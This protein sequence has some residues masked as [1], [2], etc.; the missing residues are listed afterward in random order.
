MILFLF[1]TTARPSTAY[2]VHG[3]TGSMAALSSRIKNGYTAPPIKGGTIF[4]PI[5]SSCVSTPHPGLSTFRYSY[6]CIIP[7]TLPFRPVCLMVPVTP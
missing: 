3:F 2:F 5:A 1:L 7:L 4:P 6:L